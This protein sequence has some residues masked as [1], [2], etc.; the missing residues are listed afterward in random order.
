MTHTITGKQLT[1][2][3]VDEWEKMQNTTYQFRDPEPS[4]ISLNLGSGT[5]E[6]I[7]VAADGFY[8]RG[9]RVPADDKEAETVYLA[10][11]QW[12]AWAN[13]QRN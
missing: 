8:V 10:F 3:I 4:S 1:G 13:L 7:R 5:D 9:V 11:K 12:L 6:M 2:M